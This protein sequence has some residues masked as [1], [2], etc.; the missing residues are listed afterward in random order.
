MKDDNEK[1]INLNTSM[2]FISLFKK[3]KRVSVKYKVFD[4]GSELN[5]LGF[6]E[7]YEA[8]NISPEEFFKVCKN[9]YSYRT[10]KGENDNE[11]KLIIE[12]RNT[13]KKTSLACSLENKD[14][15]VYGKTI[16]NNNNTTKKGYN[17]PNQNNN[18]CTN[19]GDNNI[20]YGNE[21]KDW[22]ER[23]EELKSNYANKIK[24]IK[25]GNA[26]LVKKFE[27]LK[28]E[29]EDEKLKNDRIVKIYLENREKYESAAKRNK[30]IMLKYGSL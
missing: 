18:N 14:E 13:N 28:K 30:D 7:T 12:N 5:Y 4:N 9:E 1:S 19:K 6:D 17:T 26:E 23:F 22:K 21:K 16:P 24:E 3:K 15:N 27:H 8:F 20:N 2:I 29:I 25:K 10:E 11:I